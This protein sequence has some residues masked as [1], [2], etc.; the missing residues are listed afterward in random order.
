MAN[1]QN[2]SWE[3]AK[4]TASSAMDKGKEAA[5]GTMEKVK[6]TASNIADKARD[7]G[8]AALNKAG[9]AASWAGHKA[10]DAM[11]AAGSGMKNLGETIRDKGPQ[12]GVL[13][14]ASSAVASGMEHAGEYLERGFSGMGEDVGGLIRRN[15]VV[16]VLIGI[17]LGFVLARLTSS[18]S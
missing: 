12:S 7:I 11:S 5:T 1:M 17:G 6:E 9:E 8:G 2:K 14:G 10:D 3:Q 13:G 15:P 4:D 18:R 16:S